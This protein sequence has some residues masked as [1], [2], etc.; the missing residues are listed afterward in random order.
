MRKAII[1]PEASE[2]EAKKNRATQKK[3]QGIDPEKHFRKKAV[4]IVDAIDGQGTVNMKKGLKKTPLILSKGAPYVGPKGG[5][6]ADPG[7]TKP[8]K[9]KTK[10]RR[11]RRIKKLSFDHLDAITASDSKD[12]KV[13]QAKQE[14]QQTLKDLKAGKPAI[15][16][17]R[18]ELFMDALEAMQ[19]SQ[20]Q[21]AAGLN[22]I[23]GR[24]QAQF[25]GYV[26]VPG[27]VPGVT[28][29]MHIR[30]K[31]DPETEH[32]LNAKPPA[33]SADRALSRP[34]Q[35]SWDVVRGLGL[36]KAMENRVRGLVSRAIVTSPNRVQ[37]KKGIYE[38]LLQENLPAEVR[39]I[40]DERA[41]QLYAK[42]LQKAQF[43]EVY[44]LEDARLEKAAR[45]R[46]RPENSARA[47]TISSSS[48]SLEKGEAR[49]GTYHARITSKGKH[50]YYYDAAKYAKEHGEHSYGAD[51]QK[52]YLSASALKCVEKAG[53]SCGFDA[54][55]GLV[56]R[57]G[58]KEVHSAVRSHVD[59]GKLK[60]SKGKFSQGK[61]DAGK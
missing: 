55:A 11:K 31:L 23:G 32:M 35:N 24:P 15:T 9:D 48:S 45:A 50:K 27:Q 21:K 28:P 12:P 20:L 40:I 14:V 39:V 42:V 16:Q 19:K 44:S 4:G 34:V 10:E 51:N 41:V 47:L 56:K 2:D 52:A 7:L 43:T 60:F 29:R 36:S 53:G 3:Y 25:T 13:I 33:W 17:A 22:L 54:F 37:L 8:W 59:S 6:Y 18:K 58:P 30:P 26:R 1:D 57:Y 61:K 38:S 49:G 5:K 46:G